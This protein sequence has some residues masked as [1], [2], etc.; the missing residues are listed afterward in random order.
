MYSHLDDPLTLFN[1]ASG[2]MYSHLDDPLTL[3]NAASGLMYSHFDDPLTDHLIQVLLY[4]F[5]SFWSISAQ[6]L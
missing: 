6:I 4:N 2:L 5:I 3:F 1:V